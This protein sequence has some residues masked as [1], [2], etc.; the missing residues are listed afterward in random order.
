MSPAPTGEIDNAK[1]AIVI[2]AG[3]AGANIAERLAARGWRVDVIEAGNTAAS[4]ASGNPAGIVLPQIAKDDALTARFSRLCYAY[5]LQ[6]LAGL[7]HCDWHPCGV[8]QIARDDAHEIQQS[9]AVKALQFPAEF[10]EFLPRLRAQEIAAQPL[11]HGG[12]WFSQGGWLIPSTLCTA[13]LAQHDPQIK[14]HFNTH[15]SRLSYDNNLW[16]AYA[17]DGQAIIAA[18]HV[19]LANAYAVNE[20]LEH[21]FPLKTIRGQISVLPADAL[22]KINPVLCRTGYL[23]PPHNGL[24][25]FGASFVNDDA[26]LTVRIN[27]HTENLQR[28]REILPQTEIANASIAKLSGRVALRTVTPDRLP[29]VGA[30]PATIVMPLR[31]VS[32]SNLVHLPGLYALLGLSA[33]GIVWAPLVAEHLACV[34]SQEQSP[35]PQNISD[36]IDAGRFYLREL[37]QHG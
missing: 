33:R 24:V 31:T 14:C 10:V 13:L 9:A 18:P 1:H 17:A 21:T 2:G 36:A 8:L 37:R 16:T 35:L 25:T 6:R 3:L 27:E 20:L 28:L 26:D 12:W 5:L 4:G 34:M 7:P 23:T 11:S 32:L 22:P 19:V 15:V 29:I 30:V